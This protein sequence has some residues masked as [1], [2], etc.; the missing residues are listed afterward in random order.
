MMAD[1][2]TALITGGSSGI[3][4]VTAGLFRARGI[5]VITADLHP[6]SDHVVDVSDVD[7]V[8]RLAERL[9]DVDIL[10][11]SAGIVGTQAPMVELG[12]EEFIRTM[13]VNVH[14]VFLMCQAFAPAMVQRGWGR[15]VNLSSIAGKE[16]APELSAYSASK[17]AVISLTKTLGQE[18]ATTGV[19]VNA[20]AP[21]LIA[22]PMNDD[23]SESVLARSRAAIP[24]GRFGA[25][26]EV[27]ELIAWIASDACSFT[28]G[29]TFDIS[30]GRARY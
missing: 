22:T 3:G 2:R 17:A 15:I 28:T 12:F 21:A 20:V 4:L 1:R 7:A 25:P 24:M 11:N 6:G 10:V 27:A 29:F 23:T 18:L 26:E 9:P 13:Q 8:A 5:G 14:S 19:L 30:G 16:G